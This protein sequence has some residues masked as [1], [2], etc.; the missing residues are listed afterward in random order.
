MLGHLLQH[1]QVHRLRRGVGLGVVDAIEHEQRDQPQV[2]AASPCDLDTGADHVGR[3]GASAEHRGD[4]V[5]AA[6]SH[7]TRGREHDRHGCRVQQRLRHRPHAVSPQDS[8]AP[9]ADDD[10]VALQ[11]RRRI[12]ESLCIRRGRDDLAACFDALRNLRQRIRE[13]RFELPAHDRRERTIGRVDARVGIV[14]RMHE[15]DMQDDIRL[16]AGQGD[17][18]PEGVEPRAVG[19]VADEEAALSHRSALLSAVPR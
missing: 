12:H 18:E 14:S 8:P 17:A 9:P 15:C 11:P 7:V 6:L 19:G 5:D 13:P 10:R 3:P 16:A 1:L 4:S 2:G